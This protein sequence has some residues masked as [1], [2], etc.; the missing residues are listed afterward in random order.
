MKTNIIEKIKKKKILEKT[1]AHFIFREPMEGKRENLELERMPRPQSS[2][3]WPEN[4][5]HKETQGP[6]QRD[7]TKE[8][9]FVKFLLNARHL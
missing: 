1:K 3:I 9:A 4:L 6:A 2:R 5:W 7:K 8:T